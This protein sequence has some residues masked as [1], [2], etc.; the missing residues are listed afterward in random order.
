MTKA[1]TK[2]RTGSGVYTNNSAQRGAF[3]NPYPQH[4]TAEEMLALSKQRKE[5]L[6]AGRGKRRK[7]R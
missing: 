4:Y 1:Y 3:G 7:R 5:Y 2:G 6:I